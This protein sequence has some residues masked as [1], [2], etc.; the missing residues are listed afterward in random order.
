MYGSAGKRIDTRYRE[1]RCYM[2]DA[3]RVLPLYRPPWLFLR[4]PLAKIYIPTKDFPDIDS[5]GQ[6]VGPRGHCPED[7][8]KQSRASKHCHSR[9]RLYQGRKGRARDS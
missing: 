6:L 5:I 4:T 8:N 9:M 2:H 3:L 7:M 1:R